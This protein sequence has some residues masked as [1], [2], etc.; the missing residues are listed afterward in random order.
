VKIF[1]PIVRARAPR[2]P[3]ATPMHR[4][5]VC[6]KLIVHRTPSKIS[7]CAYVRTKTSEPL[8]SQRKFHARRGI[9]PSSVLQSIY[10][11]L[12][13]NYCRKRRAQQWLKRTACTRYFRYV[14]WETTW[15]MK[16]ETC[17]HYSKVTRVLWISPPNLIIIDPYNL[18]LVDAFFE[19]VDLRR[20][21]KWNQINYGGF[22]K[23]MSLSLE[24]KV[25]GVIGSESEGGDCDE[26]MMRAGW[27]EPGVEWTEWGWRNEEGSWFHR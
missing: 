16:T 15:Y 1:Q 9:H 22:V 24:W 23:E 14:V 19:T 5:S 11:D 10:K 4:L 18:E 20:Q 7:G 12:R 27:G 17:K 13:L 2:P 8:N 6:H 21:S 3:L 26:V 25:E